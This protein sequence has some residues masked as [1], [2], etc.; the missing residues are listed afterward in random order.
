[1][2]DVPWD[3]KE[4]LADSIPYTRHLLVSFWLINSRSPLNTFLK[5]LVSVTLA[6]VVTIEPVSFVPAGRLSGINASTGKL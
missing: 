5:D 4:L 6:V 2:D 3:G 1:M